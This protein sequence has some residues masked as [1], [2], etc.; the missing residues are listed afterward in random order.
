MRLIP[1]MGGTTKKDDQFK[2]GQFGTGLKYVLAYM[3]RNNLS[4]RIFSG[5]TEAVIGSVNKDI[6][7]Q[8][9]DIITIYGVETSITAQMGYDWKPW[10][11]IREIW[12]NAIDEGGHTRE[13]TE[14]VSGNEATTTFYLELD[15]NFN[16]VWNNWTRY[17]IQDFEPLYSCERFAIYSGC[18]KLRLYKQGVLIYEDQS[19][20]PSVFM[21]DLKNADINEL[22]QFQG[23]VEGEIYECLVKL[24]DPQLIQFF[25][26]TCREE[27]YEGNMDYTWTWR[28]GF[29]DAWKEV[30]GNAKIIHQKAVDTIEARGLKLD[31]AASIVVPEGLY[32]ALTK[33]FEGIGALRV[34]DKVNEFYE[35]YDQNLELKVKSG[36]AILEEC[37]YFIHP[38]LK[39]IYGCFGDKTK[40]ASVNLDKKEVLISEQMLD[41][42]MFDVVSMLIEENEHF[43]TGLSDETRAF[44][45]HF[46]NLYTKTLLD[47]NEVAL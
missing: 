19:T 42:S 30:I 12:C 13:I 43:K 26:E 15:L 8:V 3:V 34:A 44:Q 14:E 25:L 47:K 9:F 41:K 40:L 17:F 27:N 5:E 46:I 35:I 21:Y 1:L 20:K 36:L 28:G 16:K 11:I 29:N 38:E 33:K 37:G 18:E 39:F 4:I 31:A 22:R 32:K 45:Q 23:H 10:M 7:G 24:T 2:I 6:S